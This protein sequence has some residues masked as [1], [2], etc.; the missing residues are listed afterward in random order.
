MAECNLPESGV[1]TEE[2]VSQGSIQIGYRYKFYINVFGSPLQTY[3]EVHRITDDSVVLTEGINSDTDQP[4]I[5]GEFTFPKNWI[6]RVTQVTATVPGTSFR[7]P[8]NGLP[9][10]L[11]HLGGMRKRTRKTVNNRKFKSKSYKKRR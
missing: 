2:E 4:S 10:K 11:S 8:L 6:T 3:A 7:F 1:I 9:K 5:Q